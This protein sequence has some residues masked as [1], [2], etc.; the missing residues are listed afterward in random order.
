MRRSDV[1]DKVVCV[2]DY[3]ENDM[4]LRDSHGKETSYLISCKVRELFSEV[5]S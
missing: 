4:L 1:R 3:V 5:L 2:L